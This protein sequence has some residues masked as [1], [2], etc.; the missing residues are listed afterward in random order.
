MRYERYISRR[1]SPIR[2][3]PHLMTY[4]ICFRRFVYFMSSSAITSAHPCD[5]NSK[6]HA[7][8][9]T[10]CMGF[11]IQS[12]L[13]PSESSS[14]RVQATYRIDKILQLPSWMPF[15]YS[16]DWTGLIPLYGRLVKGAFIGLHAAAYFAVADIHHSSGAFRSSFHSLFWKGKSSRLALWLCRIEGEELSFLFSAIF[17]NMNQTL[18]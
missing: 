13:F 1:L 6:P 14:F 8:L 4:G 12:D 15:M 18:K 5:Q 17:I 2:C 3:F 16:S 9:F 7:P 10:G 11:S